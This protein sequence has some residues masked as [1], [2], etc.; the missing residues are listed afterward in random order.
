MIV[1]QPVIKGAAN[2][3]IRYTV[4]VDSENGVSSLWYEVDEPFGGFMS[5]Q[6]DAALVALLIPA[7]NTGEDIH[8]KGTVSKRLYFNLNDRLQ[9]ILQIVMPWLKRIEIDCEGLTTAETSP[10]GVATGFSCGVDSY[11]VL[12]DYYYSDTVDG[13]KITHLFFNN[14]G[15]HGKGGEQLFN[16]RFEQIQKVTQKIGLPLIRVNS[17][18]N[19]FYD[20]ER[21]SFIQ[22]FTLRNASVPYLL[23]KMIGRFYYASGLSYK[24]H[25]IRETYSASE[26]EA[27]IIPMLSAV[28]LDMVTVGSKYSRVEKTIQIAKIPDTYSTL[29]VCTSS[30]K[31]DKNCSKC[32]KCMRTM[33]T[34]DLAGKLDLYSEVF[35]IETFRK[36]KNGYIAHVLKGRNSLDNEIIQYAKSINHAFPAS[37]HLKSVLKQMVGKD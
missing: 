21:L 23:N 28:G 34:L 31:L 18:L 36:R 11:S 35:D 25:R 27:I 29:D 1:S 19:E 32:I 22:T 16:H 6:S 3:K 5:E 20:D 7:M 14:V 8:F 13:F 30:E 33:L 4:N 17:N 26:S 9:H 10:G 12:A 2:G 24:G 15:S 37:A